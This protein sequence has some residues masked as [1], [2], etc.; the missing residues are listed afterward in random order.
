MVGEAEPLRSLGVLLSEDAVNAEALRM[1][2]VKGN[3]ELTDAQKVTARAAL[4]TKGLADASGDLERTSGSTANQLRKFTGSAGNLATVVGGSVLPAIDSILAGVNSFTS[5]VGAWVERNQAAFTAVGF[6]LRDAFVNFGE[7]LSAIIGGL[8]KFAGEV[9]SYLGITSGSVSDFGAKVANVVDGIGFAWRNLPEI[10]GIVWI[11]IKEFG[12]NTVATFEALLAN[13]STFAGYLATNWRALIVDAFQGVIA[14]VWNLGKNLAS[15]GSALVQFLLD[16]MSGF[17]V[18]WTPLLDGFKATAEKL[19]AMIQPSL[20]SLQGEV[21]T[22]LATIATNEVARAERIAKEIKAKT[23][24]I[25]PKRPTAVDN[26]GLEQSKKERSEL[27]TFAKSLTDK[28]RDPIE[29][30]NEQIR[31]I[32]EAFK[33]NLIN[34]NTYLAAHLKAQKELNNVKGS[35]KLLTLGSEETR[36]AILSSQT[37]RSEGMKGLAKT[38]LESLAQERQTNT[39]LAKIATS[40]GAPAEEVKM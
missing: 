4:I 40:L 35:G 39:H 18:D 5:V 11:R 17:H 22:K 27:V 1:G 37:G 10:I 34:E 31:K 28:S 12:I 19:P 14:V 2:L 26:K 7:G 24:A 32:G 8:S 33:Y 38:A 36:E 21:D 30:Y 25:T 20:V 9:G 16:P 13:A 23:D 3:E 29:K 15:L 6:W